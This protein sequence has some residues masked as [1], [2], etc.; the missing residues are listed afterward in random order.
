MFLYYQIVGYNYEIKL[1]ILGLMKTLFREKIM[2]S[3]GLPK[4]SS[5]ISLVGKDF[6]QDNIIR[7]FIDF[8]ILVDGAFAKK[9]VN[10]RNDNLVDQWVTNPVYCVILENAMTHVGTGVTYLL[11]SKKY[12][13]ETSAGWGKYSTHAYKKF[14][15]RNKYINSS[16]PVFVF[17]GEG[18]HGVVDDLSCMIA[19][20]EKGYRFKVAI[21]KNNNWMSKLIDIFIPELKKS[22]IY[23][24]HNSWVSFPK[25][26]SVTKS[27][28]GEFTNPYLI[29]LIN[30]KSKKLSLQG[31]KYNR[32]FISR[33]DTSRR[34]FNG[35]KELEK[36]YVN[37]GFKPLILSNLSIENQISIFQSAS[38][39]VGMQGAGLVNIVWAKKKQNIKEYFLDNH[40]SSAISVICDYLK[41]NHNCQS[42]KISL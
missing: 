40:Y 23:F 31:M 24:S 25:I 39:V 8:F 34:T 33:T 2:S 3:I 21:G 37:E 17:S 16:L 5:V 28:M 13:L 11:N 42:I 35:E 32:I 41:H 14:N 12:I 4:P 27:W 1:D 29:E 19:L 6:H 30:E 36:R 38:S 18:F 22:K 10:K 9:N 20:W 26:I 7:D 15:G